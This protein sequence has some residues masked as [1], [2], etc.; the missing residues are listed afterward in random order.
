MSDIKLNVEGN[1]IDLSSIG[2]ELVDGT[3]AI[4][5][6]LLIRLRF[7]QGEYFLDTRRGIPYF[8]DI[9][10]KN[11]DLL[12]IRAIFREAIRETP[13]VISITRFDMFVNTATRRLRTDFTV[14]VTTQTEPLDFSEEFIIG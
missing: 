9:L 3:D 5:Q 12:A 13:G 2:L 8:E 10:I 4:A 6:H 14:L 1:D 11:P 7:V